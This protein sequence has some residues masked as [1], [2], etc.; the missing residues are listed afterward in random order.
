MIKDIVKFKGDVTFDTSKSDGT[1]RKL[2]DVSLLKS[3]GW[4][5]KISLREGLANTYQ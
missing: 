1:P 2:L 3:I 4:V 5:S